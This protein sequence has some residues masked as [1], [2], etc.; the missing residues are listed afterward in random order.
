MMISELFSRSK[1]II[2]SYLVF[3][4]VRKIEYTVYS[5]D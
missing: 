3:E 2:E 4:S 1:K 5:S